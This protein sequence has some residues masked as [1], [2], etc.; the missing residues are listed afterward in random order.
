MHVKYLYNL[1]LN[2]LIFNSFGLIDVDNDTKQF[3]HLS[4]RQGVVYDE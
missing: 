2:R 3:I 1:I 4:F